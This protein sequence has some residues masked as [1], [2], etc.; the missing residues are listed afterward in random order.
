MCNQFC[1]IL[2]IVLDDNPVVF[3][4]FS[5]SLIRSLSSL[6][7]PLSL[8]PLSLS[9]PL[10]LPPSLPLS[11]YLS[12]L[13][14]SHDRLC[15][16]LLFFVELFHICGN[17]LRLCTPWPVVFLAEGL[18]PSPPSLT[19]HL[20][21]FSITTCYIHMYVHMYWYCTY[22]DLLAGMLQLHTISVGCFLVP[23]C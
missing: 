3:A 14:L 12:S 11:L 19:P 9:P 4:T 23:Q 22:M 21:L 16:P 17:T 10:S 6:S 15:L 2:I 8:P 7:L 18:G 13:S 20:F 5:L 1:Y